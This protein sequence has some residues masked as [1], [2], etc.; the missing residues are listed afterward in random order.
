MVD[1][2]LVASAIFSSATDWVLRCSVT[3]SFTSASKALPPSAWARLKAPSPACQ[4][5][6][7]ESRMAPASGESAWLSSGAAAALLPALVLALLAVLAVVLAAG[8]AVVAAPDVC[9]LVTMEAPEKVGLN[10]PHSKPWPAPAVGA[11]F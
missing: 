11:H 2:L 8:L 5:C 9:S 1:I 7:A 6:W 4:I 3:P 10:T